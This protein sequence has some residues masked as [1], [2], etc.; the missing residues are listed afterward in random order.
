MNFIFG[1]FCG[2]SCGNIRWALKKPPSLKKEKKG[3]MKPWTQNL[4]VY[5]MYI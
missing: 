3:K 4:V 5:A 2:Y 1:G